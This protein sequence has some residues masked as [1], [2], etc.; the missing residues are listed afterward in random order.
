MSGLSIDINSL[1]ISMMGVSAEMVES[2]VEGLEEEIMRKLGALSIGRG[3]ITEST[4]VDLGE[5][6]IGPVEMNGT[7]D[8]GGIRALIADQLLFALQ[9]ELSTEG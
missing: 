6:A 2:A 1:H 8:A 9:S 4:M 7:L 3:N 5:L